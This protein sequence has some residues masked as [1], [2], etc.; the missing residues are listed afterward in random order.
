[1]TTAAQRFEADKKFAYR[2]LQDARQYVTDFD[3][4]GSKAEALYERLARAANMLYPWTTDGTEAQAQKAMDYRREIMSILSDKIGPASRRAFSEQGGTH[5][6]TKKKSPR[7]LDREIAEVVAGWGVGGGTSLTED[8][9]AKLTDDHINEIYRDAQAR[10]DTKTAKLAAKAAYAYD[11][12]GEKIAALAAHL[13]GKKG[14]RGKSQLR[15]HATTQDLIGALKGR[16]RVKFSDRSKR[17]NMDKAQPRWIAFV[18]G[19][20]GHDVSGEGATK[21]AAVRAAVADL[22]ANIRRHLETL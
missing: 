15:S 20:L 22:P 4:T 8:R 12:P 21:E 2:A 5:H 17:P 18:Q 7:Q 9:V 6:A 11:K 10:G 14:R 13:A 16:A 19:Y 1:M 3:R